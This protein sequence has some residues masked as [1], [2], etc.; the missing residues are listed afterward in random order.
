VDIVTGN[1]T[2]STKLRILLLDPYSVSNGMLD[3]TIERIAHFASLTGGKDVA[4]LLLLQS[5]ASSTFVTAK[6]LN[7]GVANSEG[8]FAYSQLQAELIN[9]PE[10]PT[11]PIL[12]LSRIETVV[13]SLKRHITALSRSRV[14][15]SSAATPF[16]LL[17]LCTASP[18]MSQQSAFIL[19]DLFTDLRDLAM[20]CS[21]S[22]SAPNS[23]SPSIRAASSQ[24]T[25]IPDPSVTPQVRPSPA[26][27]TC[28]LKKLRSLVGDQECQDIIDFWKEEWTLE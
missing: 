8:V 3:E 12:P 11:I 19:T 14:S 21:A 17:Q 28:K 15:N 13:D 9:R 26:S 5:P 16:D 7:D 27:A 20:T 10:I 25:S 18:P 1:T 22:T 4:V 2:T 6:Q 24:T 23:S